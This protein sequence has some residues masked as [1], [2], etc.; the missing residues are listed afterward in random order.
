M[1]SFK[2]QP[3]ELA[4]PPDTT[5]TSCRWM[6]VGSSERKARQKPRSN[7]ERFL[8]WSSTWPEQAARGAWAR[9][10]WDMKGFEE[11]AEPSAEEMHWADAWDHATDA[12]GEVVG[13]DVN[14]IV[15]SLAALRR[16]S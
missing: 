8:A 3:L 11:G 9:E 12:A 7:S 2:S 14:L 15:E 6:R 4:Q 16:S 13:F 1:R 10:A 5:C